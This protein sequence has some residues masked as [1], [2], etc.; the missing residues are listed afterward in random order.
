MAMG[1]HYSQLSSKERDLISVLRAEGHTV[2]AIARTVCRP[3]STI[4][5]ELKR[6]SAPVHKGRYL[7]HRA[8]QRAVDRRSIASKRERLRHDGLKPMVMR[9][10]RLGWS[11]EQISGYL[12]RF[13]PEVAISHEAIYQWIYLDARKLI[14]LLTRA[15]RRR[16]CRG[17]SRRH[18]TCHIPGRKP[19]T[20]R[21]DKANLRLRAGDWEVDTAI[22]RQSLQAL[23]VIVDRK[24][25]LSK[26]SLLPAKTSSAVS[27]CINRRL[28]KLPR[29]KRRT[30]TY[31][32]GSENVDHARCNA[33]LGTQSYFCAP[34]H[35]WEK[36]T[37]ENTV[38]LVRRRFPKGTDFSKIKPREIK[39]LEQRLNNRPRKCLDFRTPLESFRNQSVA[40]RS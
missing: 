27:Q 1:K 12:K 13:H 19:I 37:V 25:R 20:E 32:N 15:H 40:L 2:R 22:S 3:S 7:A 26:L 30:L 21:S 23:L 31:D 36:G 35:S 10:L 11:P 16:K 17:Y 4:C 29:S 39:L 9:K 8:H 5:R 28:S 24:S 38:G 34:Y 14:P 18:K 6:N 33:A